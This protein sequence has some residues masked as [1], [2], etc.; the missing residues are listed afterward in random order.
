MALCARA[1]ELSSTDTNMRV[2]SNS[3][4]RNRALANRQAVRCTSMGFSIQTDGNQSL[5]DMTKGSSHSLFLL[6]QIRKLST[7]RRDNL[8]LW[9]PNF[10]RNS[11]NSKY[12]C[13]SFREFA[14]SA[15]ERR[16]EGSR[17]ANDRGSFAVGR[18]EFRPGLSYGVALASRGHRL[19]GRLVDRCRTPAWS[20]TNLFSTAR[21]LA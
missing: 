18:R 14:N 6:R 4:G 10:S 8:R 21:G 2:V 13:A 12:S 20:A 15:G 5:R 17:G 1:R 9:C 19:C 7:E 16:T 3:R 11:R